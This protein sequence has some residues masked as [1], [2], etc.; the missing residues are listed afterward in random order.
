M[1]KKI[2][3]IRDGYMYYYMLADSRLEVFRSLDG[4]DIGNDPDENGLFYISE[5]AKEEAE[6]IFLFDEDGDK[7]SLWEANLG[8]IAQTPTV[9]VS[10][11][12]KDNKKQDSGL[13]TFSEE[14]NKTSKN[15]EEIF[16]LKVTPETEQ[17]GSDY[18]IVHNH[19]NCPICETENSP[20][21]QFFDL[22][23]DYEED[24]ISCKVC[25][26]EFTK[27]SGCWYGDDLKVKLID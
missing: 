5:I 23:D 14:L 3:L 16:D 4:F 9:I 12:E 26:S 7:Y 13:I 18:V 11:W 15:T 21:E 17:F 10:E 8:C 24:L 1:K 27:V 22:D 6:K 25:N 2:F 19:I 20:T